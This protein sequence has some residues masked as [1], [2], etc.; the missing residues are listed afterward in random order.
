MDG[1]VIVSESESATSSSSPAP[2]SAGIHAALVPGH[3]AEGTGAGLGFVAATSLLAAS[4][5]R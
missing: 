5:S 3:F 1:T 4:S 2:I